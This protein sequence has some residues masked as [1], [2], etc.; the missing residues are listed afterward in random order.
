[1]LQFVEDF[2]ID[3]VISAELLEKFAQTVLQIVLI[4]EL[5]YRLVNLLTMPD[6]G[7]AAEFVGPF[8]RAYEPRCYHTG[9]LR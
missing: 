4:A 3:L 8:A 9:K 2:D 7:L 5:E 1:M 6:D